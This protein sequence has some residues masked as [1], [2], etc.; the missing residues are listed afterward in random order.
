MPLGITQQICEM[1]NQLFRYIPCNILFYG[2]RIWER[3]ILNVQDTTSCSRLP[4]NFISLNNCTHSNYRLR[5]C[6]E[7]LFSFI[8]F[9]KPYLVNCFGCAQ[10]QQSFYSIYTVNVF[11]G[12]R[13]G[14]QFPSYQKQD[15][16]IL[17]TQVLSVFHSITYHIMVLKHD[18]QKGD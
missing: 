15:F 8:C 6:N 17:K 2:S 12:S 11:N 9:I 1:Q 14:Y 10:F 4:L 3:A 16:L 13:K 7:D 5:C 18:R